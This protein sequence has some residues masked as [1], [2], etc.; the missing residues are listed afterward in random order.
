MIGA[1]AWWRLRA[2]GPTPLD[3]GV[4]PGL[5]LPTRG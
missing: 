2:D 1:A 5:R 4:D 3:T